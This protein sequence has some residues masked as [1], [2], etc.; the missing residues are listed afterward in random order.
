MLIVQR[1]IPSVFLSF[2]Q[3]VCVCVPQCG[4]LSGKHKLLGGLKCPTTIMHRH[5]TP[6]CMY[7]SLTRCDMYTHASPPSHSLNLYFAE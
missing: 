3:S 2:F 1:F 7:T 5:R 6:Y 4:I